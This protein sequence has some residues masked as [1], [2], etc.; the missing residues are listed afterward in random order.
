MS[1][2]YLSDDIL[3]LGILQRDSELTELCTLRTFETKLYHTLPDGV[4]NIAN[5]ERAG[6]SSAYYHVGGDSRINDLFGGEQ[7]FLPYC[8]IP[9]TLYC[10][11]LWFLTYL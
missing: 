4:P 3:G 5:I 7:I 11:R 10:S 6:V 8:D 9:G 2:S 1:V